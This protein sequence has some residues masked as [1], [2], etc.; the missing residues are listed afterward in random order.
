MTDQSCLVGGN[1]S[2]QIPTQQASRQAMPCQ[3]SSTKQCTRTVK[4]KAK[5][6]VSRDQSRG[7]D[8]R[9]Q[10]ALSLSWLTV[11]RV[12]RERQS[13]RKCEEKDM[14]LKLVYIKRQSL[15]K[16]KYNKLC[17]SVKLQR[18]K[19]E[20]AQGGGMSFPSTTS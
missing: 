12:Q 13:L 6:V 16:F 20:R 11:S 1:F 18:K 7:Q 17:R 3:S 5:G 10:I 8:Q 14:R 15:Y 9:R 4:D 2:K 19:R